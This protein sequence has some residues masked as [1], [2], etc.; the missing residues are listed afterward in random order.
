M[1]CWRKLPVI[2][3]QSQAGP[4][5]GGLGRTRARRRVTAADHRLERCKRRASATVRR[6]CRV[7]DGGGGE[8]DATLAGRFRLS[9]ERV[10][11]AGA[12]RRR[13]A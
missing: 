1:A 3:N 7:G 10:A 4:P 8:D 12:P 6:R 13:G 11:R 2:K 9:R 5:V